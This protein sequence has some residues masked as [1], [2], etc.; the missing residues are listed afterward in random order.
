MDVSQSNVILRLKSGETLINSIERKGKMRMPV[1][2]LSGGGRVTDKTYAKLTDPTN[3]LVEPVSFALF[4]D[5][6]PQEWRWK[7]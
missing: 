2:Y 5:C 6:E 7:E 3:R 4:P 1:R